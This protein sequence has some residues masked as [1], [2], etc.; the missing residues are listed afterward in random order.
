[1]AG[2][3]SQSFVDIEAWGGCFL[4]TPG[5]FLFTGIA[6]GEGKKSNGSALYAGPNPV[7]VIQR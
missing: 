7:A 6:K 5:R 2:L 4:S 3:F 1:M